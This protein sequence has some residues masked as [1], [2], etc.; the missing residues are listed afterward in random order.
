MDQN[1]SIIKKI[2]LGGILLLIS[3]LFFYQIINGEYYSLRAKNNYVRVIPLRAI[4]GSIFDR[5]GAFLAYD[6][7]TF[8]ISVIPYQIRNKKDRLFKE[9]SEFLKYDRHLIYKNY[10]KN[11]KSFFSPVDIIIDISK[12]SALR[13]EE[14]FKDS[15][16][17]NPQPKRYYPYP[18]QFAHV[19]GYVKEVASFYEKLKKYGYTPLERA[20]FSGVEQYYDAYLKG[21]DGGDLIEVNAKGRIA[22]F[23]GKRIPQKGKDIYLAIDRRIQEIASESINKRRGVIILMDSD[24]GEIISLYSSPS[25]DSNCFI[26]GKNVSRFFNDVRNSPLLNRATQARYPI[27]SIFK[28]LSGVAA[29]E[30]KKITQHT[31]FTCKG[32]LDLGSIQFRCGDIHGSE[33]LRDALAHSCNVY[34]YN[35][36]LILGPKTMAKY[37]MR[38][39]MNSLTGID[40]PYEKKGV[41]PTPAWK[42][43]ALRKNWFSG[44]T[45]NLSIGQGYLSTTPL[46]VIA[47]INI[48]ANGGYLVTPRILKEIDGTALNLTT[49]VHLGIKDGNL[50]I[51]KKGLRDVVAKK[52]GTAHMLEGLNLEIAGKTGTAQTKGNSH[53]WFAGFFPYDQPKYTILSFIEN[54]GSS[55]EAVKVMYTFLQKI[56]AES[57]LQIN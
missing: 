42:K 11:L 54:G 22:G 19:L 39:G 40:L 49:K 16:L 55:L 14:K 32:K 8:N 46:E 17:I 6:K 33:K 35:L 56:M 43:K 29:L 7:A 47:A 13:L 51:I 48:F 30:E 1:A 25:F 18:Y 41:V 3:V 28:P 50:K 52:S 36:G 34:F 2:Y 45:L 27:G 24:S 21:E 10:N 12:I 5:N 23:L 20:G 44:D 31:A 57:L 53:A 9:L 15:L 26:E 4:R 38:F 37:A